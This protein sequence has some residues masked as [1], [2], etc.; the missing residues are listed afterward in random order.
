MTLTEP[1]RVLSFNYTLRDT[2][3]QLI[4]E[5]SEGPLTFLTGGGQILP[6]LENELI[7][8][9][10]GQKKTVSLPAADAYGLPDAKHVMDVPKKE[11]AHLKLEVGAFLQMNM[12]QQAKVVRI[13]QITD[14]AVTLDGNH[15]LAGVDLVFDVEVVN[16][17]VASPEEVAHGH[18]H[19]PGGHHH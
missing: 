15:P 7:G 9:L 10:I 3:G 8:M 4:D 2:Q 17:R 18:V 13:T 6:K 11:L 5:S 16:S 1:Q 19:G 14:E 12:G